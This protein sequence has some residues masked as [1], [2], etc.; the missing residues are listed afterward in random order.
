[1]EQRPKHFQFTPVDLKKA[2]L[3]KPRKSKIRFKGL[4]DQTLQFIMPQRGMLYEDYYMLFILCGGACVSI[5]LTYYLAVFGDYGWFGY[6]IPL[7]VWTILIYGSYHEYYT[8]RQR[9]ILEISKHSF[10]IKNIKKGKEK[11]EKISLDEIILFKLASFSASVIYLR[12]EKEKE[13]M[14][15][16]YASRNEQQWLIIILRTIVYNV[17]KNIV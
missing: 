14:F 17:T 15:M 4:D 12:D 9:Q 11:L 1:M 5:Y 3:N 6:L 10:I 8:F 16:E 13:A 2:L 7:I